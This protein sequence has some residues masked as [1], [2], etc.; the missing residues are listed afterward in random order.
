MVEKEGVR[1]HY[2]L[3]V[4]SDLE[5]K[6]GREYFVG[7]SRQM[8]A[9]GFGCFAFVE[10]ATPRHVD[11]E[12]NPQVD[13]NKYDSAFLELYTSSLA[14]IEIQAASASPDNARQVLEEVLQ[15]SV[16]D[17]SFLQELKKRRAWAGYISEESIA[18]WYDDKR[19]A[20]L[21][22]LA[23]KGI[24]LQEKAEEKTEPA[25]VPE[26]PKPRRYRLL[27]GLAIANTFLLAAMMAA[28]TAGVFYG[29][30]WLKKSQE[31]MEQKMDMKER[32][33]IYQFYEFAD[34]VD[35]PEDEK[36]KKAKHKI[37][38]AERVDQVLKAYEERFIDKA[39][40]RYRKIS[41]QDY[42]RWNDDFIRR[43][44]NGE[45]DFDKI[46]ESYFRKKME[47]K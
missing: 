45:I 34:R 30:S 40:E 41:V 44:E 27:Y 28:G 13:S 19:R 39:E 2:Q 31:S 10:A 43:L 38:L 24:T 36:D 4:F 14:R 9:E 5:K 25:A 12:G 29:V 37:P 16:A 20:A 35:P 17:D 7:Y 15:T 22:G 23:K 47:G 3:P 26:A 21:R 32:A 33:Y 46:M 11:D 8:Q 6:V 1:Q 42:K 18:A